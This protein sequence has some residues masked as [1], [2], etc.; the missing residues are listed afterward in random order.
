MLKLKIVV[1]QR[2][3]ITEDHTV[4]AIII[5]KCILSLF[6]GYNARYLTRVDR[7]AKVCCNI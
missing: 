6:V 4:A 5:S 7:E 3:F 1:S 2:Y